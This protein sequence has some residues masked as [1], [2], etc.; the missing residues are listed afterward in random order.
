MEQVNKLQNF[1][2]LAYQRYSPDAIIDYDRMAASYARL[3]G[4]HVQV[5][6]EWCCLDLACG[7]GNFLAYL[8]ANGITG[9]VGV[10]LT[11][12]AI[13]RATKEFGQDRVACID[14]F[15]FLE[16]RKQG[17]DLISALDFVEHLQPDELF[18]LLSGVREG[19]SQNGLFL[20]RT[21]NAS[22]PFGMAARYNDITHELC[23]TAGALG[24]VMQ[25][26]GFDVIDVWE[27]IGYP[28]NILQIFHYF[29]WQCLRFVYRMMD[30]IETGVWG[31]GIMTRNY[32]MLL[33]KR[34]GMV[35]ND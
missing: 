19:L 4:R 1:R 30:A 34:E 25:R 5:E 29:A 21:P 31:P 13:A 9:F 23:F 11:E 8:R 28:K 26:A 16:K 24:D 32:W 22:A 6:S 27:D 10:D 18:R 17:F 3:V 15:D 2:N 12:A 35:G 7:Y 14:A 20:V 33:R